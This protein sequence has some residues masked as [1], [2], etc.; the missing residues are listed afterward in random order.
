MTSY[1]MNLSVRC[2]KLTTMNPLGKTQIKDLK[3]KII[4]V[5][6][7]TLPLISHCSMSHCVYKMINSSMVISFM[8][9]LNMLKVPKT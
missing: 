4:I 6:I 2:K 3:E 7:F 8:K 1:I 9:G 5:C